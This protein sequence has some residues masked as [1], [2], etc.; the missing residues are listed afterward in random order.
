ML[1][2]PLPAWLKR[3]L[4][5]QAAHIHKACNTNFEGLH[6]CPQRY[7]QAAAVLAVAAAAPHVEAFSGS[8]L[9]F[10][11]KLLPA[12]APE[13]FGPYAQSEPTGMPREPPP[14]NAQL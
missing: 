11:T 8:Y 1:R 14:M 7:E 9:D 12:K 13:V 6:A 2:L 3:K 10:E 5:A 4:P